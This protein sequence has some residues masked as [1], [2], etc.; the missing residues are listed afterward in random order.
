MR[1]TVLRRRR[2]AARAIV[3]ALLATGCSRR[4][5]APAEDPRGAAARVAGAVITNG[6]VLAEAK[7]AL[8]AVEARHAE[9]EYAAKSRALDAIVER[10]LLAAKAKREGLTVD[11]LLARDVLARVPE[12]TEP[13][14]RAVYDATKAEGKSVPPYEESRAEIARFVRDRTLQSMR[15][16]YVGRL[17]SEARVE[18]LLPPALPPKVDVKANGPSLGDPKAPVTIVEFADYECPFCATVEPELRRVLADRP[19]KVRLVFQAFPL[20]IHPNALAASQA[21]LCAGEQGRF[22]EMHERLWKSRDA[23]GAADLRAHARALGLDGA[24]FDAC[25]ASGRTAPAVEESRRLGEALGL[26]STP[27]LFVNGRM[28]VG[29]QPAGKLERLVDYELG[30]AAK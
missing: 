15:Q 29:A 10:R 4:T 1:K 17:R 9:E 26:E 19:G 22:W 23:L 25:L 27:T 18:V 7:P 2:S 21:A 8:T 6:D 3:L 5:A 30:A 12:P 14:L 20:S 11:T 16:A 24:R 28:L 13:E